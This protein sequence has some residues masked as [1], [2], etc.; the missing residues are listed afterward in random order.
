MGPSLMCS[1]KA[2]LGWEKIQIVALQC[3]QWPIILIGADKLHQ[4]FWYFR[5]TASVTEIG[6]ATMPWSC[7][8]ADMITKRLGV[9]VLKFSFFSDALSSIWRGSGPNSASS[10]LV[11]LFCCSFRQKKCEIY[12]VDLINNLNQAL[13]LASP[14]LDLSAPC[15]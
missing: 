2:A 9:Q 6:T 7:F 10:S 8:L 5:W 11:S 15:E 14:T 4:S 3:V 12:K 1:D 13:L